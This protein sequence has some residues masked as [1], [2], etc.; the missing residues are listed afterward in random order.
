MRNKSRLVLENIYYLKNS[1]QGDHVNH[2]S[3]LDGIIESIKESTVRICFY[4]QIGL[5]R[6]VATCG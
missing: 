3:Q 2:L 5:L 1:L 4:L 6:R